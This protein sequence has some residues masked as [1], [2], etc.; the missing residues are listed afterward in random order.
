VNAIYAERVLPRYGIPL[1]YG[2][3][4]RN[5]NIA[6]GNIANDVFSVMINPAEGA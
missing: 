2:P 6:N 4:R 5:G 3:M 1:D